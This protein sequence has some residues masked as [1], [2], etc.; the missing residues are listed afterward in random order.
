MKSK[1]LH[2]TVWFVFG[3]VVFFFL[4]VD[5]IES[6]FCPLSLLVIPWM[7]NWLFL[8]FVKNFSRPGNLPVDFLLK[9]MLIHSIPSI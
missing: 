7:D 1:Q 5:V 6:V 4:I 2:K 9:D 8:F 3:L